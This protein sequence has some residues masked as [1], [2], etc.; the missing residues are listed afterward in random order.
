MVTVESLYLH[1]ELLQFCSCSSAGGSTPSCPQVLSPAPT[2]EPWPVPPPCTDVATASC[3]RSVSHYLI[4]KPSANSY[5]QSVI[6]CKQKSC[7]ITWPL[8]VSRR[9]DVLCLQAASDSPET[10]SVQHS[11]SSSSSVDAQVEANNRNHLVADCTTSDQQ[12]EALS[13]DSFTPGIFHSRYSFKAFFPQFSVDAVCSCRK[14]VLISCLFFRWFFT[15]WILLFGEWCKWQQHW[16]KWCKSK[17]P[18]YFS[19]QTKSLSFP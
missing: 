15:A 11:G 2:P 14:P 18:I 7:H 17:M 6:Q 8:L 10:S 1:R 16:Y 4:S 5:Q 3:L 9:E 13:Y 19:F 12:R